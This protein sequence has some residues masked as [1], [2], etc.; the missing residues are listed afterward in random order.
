MNASLDKLSQTSSQLVS[1]YNKSAGEGNNQQGAPFLS[2]QT[3]QEYHG[4]EDRFTQQLTAY[5]KKQFFEVWKTKEYLKFLEIILNQLLEICS[6]QDYV[7]CGTA[8]LGHM[9]NGDKHFIS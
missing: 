6:L 8:R 3:L 4:V 1:M 5:T 7:A 2:Q 9:M